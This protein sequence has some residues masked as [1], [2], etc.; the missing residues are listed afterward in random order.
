MCVQ[1]NFQLPMLDSAFLSLSCI[2]FHTQIKEGV[3]LS[4]HF[5]KQDK[6]GKGAGSSP[7]LSPFHPAPLT[8]PVSLPHIS[9]LRALSCCR[10]S[11]GV[12]MMSC[13]PQ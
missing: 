6:A 11:P 4:S 13:E 7:F 5:Q 10:T 3:K 8:H 9:L 1:K 2:F 12:L